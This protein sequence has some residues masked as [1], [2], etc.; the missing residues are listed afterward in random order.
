MLI[1]LLIVALDSEVNFSRR[2]YLCVLYVELD[3]C[4]RIR[5]GGAHR[6]KRRRCDS[7]APYSALPPFLLLLLLFHNRSRRGFGRNKTAQLTSTSPS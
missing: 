3:Y 6:G 5:V 4:T 7:S 2:D 1:V